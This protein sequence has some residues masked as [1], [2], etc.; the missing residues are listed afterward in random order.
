VAEAGILIVAG[1]DTTATSLAATIFYLVHYPHALDRLEREI[2]TGF[3]TW[4]TFAS[5]LS[6]LL[7]NTCLLALM[8][9]CDF[10]QTLELSSN[11]R[12]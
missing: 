5:D 1:T 12:F 11:S 6:C 2:R 3:R 10:H 7:A 8:K 4:R 9:Q